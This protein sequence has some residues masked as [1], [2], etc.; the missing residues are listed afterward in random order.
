MFAITQNNYFILFSISVITAARPKP[1][2]KKPKRG[3]F[4]IIPN[5]IQLG[6]VESLEFLYMLF[7]HWS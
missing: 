2:V 5:T 1:K 3:F 6:K 7:R 4:D